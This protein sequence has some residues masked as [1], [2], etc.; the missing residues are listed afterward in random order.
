MSTVR[1]RSNHGWRVITRSTSQKLFWTQTQL[2]W[3]HNVHKVLFQSIFTITDLLNISFVSSV[4]FW[5]NLP[6]KFDLW[7]STALLFGQKVRFFHYF[8]ENV[9][10]IFRF[11]KKFGTLHVIFRPL[12][13]KILDQV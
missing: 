7:V 2:C 6:M 9:E 11:L 1:R 3:L 4:Q 5:K 13:F 8:W 12:F 10:K